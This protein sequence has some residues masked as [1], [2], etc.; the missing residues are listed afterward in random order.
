MRRLLSIVVVILLLLTAAV[1]IG[2]NSDSVT[3]GEVEQGPQGEQGPAGPQGEQGP[4]GPEGPQGER[5]PVG[6]QGEQ[7]EKGDSYTYTWAP[8]DVG[9][10]HEVE[11]ASFSGVGDK[12]TDDFWIGGERFRLSWTATSDSEGGSIA[13]EV[14]K[15]TEENSV[16]EST[17]VSRFD[18]SVKSATVSDEHHV[19]EG[20]G[21]YYLVVDQSASTEWE[22]QVEE[23]YDPAE[24][25]EG[26]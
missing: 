18:A 7:G 4:P 13:V 9:G 24:Y 2:C 25:Q 17:E 8:P 6:P 21:T 12:A 15:I 23:F 5:G 26:S 20:Y 14:Y 22:I 11:D 10:W 16:L 3:T 1:C 19:Y